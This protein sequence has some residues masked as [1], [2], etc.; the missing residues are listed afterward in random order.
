LGDQ[1]SIKA[2]HNLVLGMGAVPLSI[3][4]KKVDGYIRSTKAKM[5]TQLP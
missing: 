1:F 3:L 2:F 4:E 5:G